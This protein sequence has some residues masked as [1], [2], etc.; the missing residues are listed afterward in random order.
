VTGGEV[1]RAL[2]VDGR[3]VGP[4]EVADTARRRSRGLLGRDG[5]DGALL[6]RPA[7]QVHTFRMRFAIDVAFCDRDL[8]VL[9]VATLVPG[10]MSRL[11]LRS[12]A[13]LEAEAG[14]FARWDLAVG[15]RLAVAEAA[16]GDA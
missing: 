15:S 7:N 16:R 10:R 2:L 9:R 4:L 8:V 1:A 14:S 5:I 12:R 3:R 11:V 6:L 13:V